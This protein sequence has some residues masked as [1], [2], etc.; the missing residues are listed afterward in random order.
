[1]KTVFATALVA[2]F[3]LGSVGFASDIKSTVRLTIS[4]DG[5][6]AVD[7]SDPLVLALSHVYVGSFI[8][9]PVEAPD[10]SLTRFTVTF[11]IQQRDDMVKVR[12]YEVVYCRN[13]ATGEG[14]VYLP[15]SGD[16]YRRNIS[17]IL[18]SGQDGRWHRASDEWSAAIS[19]YWR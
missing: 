19:A 12:G 18:R 2:A 6:S 1:M 13:A 17:T 3:A 5:R 11:D 7:V 10:P 9:A 14:F 4:A 16:S 8:G 15:G